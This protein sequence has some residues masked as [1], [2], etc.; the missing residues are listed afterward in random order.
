MTKML[1]VSNEIKALDA[2]DLE[3]IFQKPCKKKL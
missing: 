1:Q 2:F 3:L